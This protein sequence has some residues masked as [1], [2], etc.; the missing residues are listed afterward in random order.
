MAPLLLTRA[1]RQKLAKL[2][3]MLS[4]DVDGEALAAARAIVRDLKKVGLD[5][6]DLADFVV[7]PAREAYRAPVYSPRAPSAEV[8]P[9]NEYVA[10]NQLLVACSLCLQN[11]D[12]LTPQEL[13]FIRIFEAHLVEQRPFG[14]VEAERLREISS[15]F[16]WNTA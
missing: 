15:R 13:T 4:S 14:E 12:K 9:Q 1:L 16:E 6:H 3:R 2:I 8:R 7:D 5:I 10:R 11:I